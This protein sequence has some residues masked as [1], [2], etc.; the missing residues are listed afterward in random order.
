MMMMMVF[1]EGKEVTIMMMLTMMTMTM[2]MMMMMMF[3]V[4]GEAIEDCGL[5]GALGDFQV[6][7]SLTSLLQSWTFMIVIIVFTIGSW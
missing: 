6:A 3:R 1:R 7:A 2:M 5:F 4:N